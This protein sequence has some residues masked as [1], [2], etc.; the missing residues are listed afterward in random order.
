MPDHGNWRCSAI[1]PTIM[2]RVA[3]L[4]GVVLV[5]AAGCTGNADAPSTSPLST[6]SDAFSSPPAMGRGWLAVDVHYVTPNIFFTEGS[7]S[8]LKVID[9]EGAVAGV[10]RSKNATTFFRQRLVPGTY[11]IR[12]FRRPCDGSC[13]A[14]DPPRDRC[15]FVADVSSGTAHA[16]VLRVRVGDYSSAP[17]C[18]V[19]DKGSAIDI[20]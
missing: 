9:S 6:P 5:L 3:R 2:R 7:I 16:L 15:T 8:F 17:D 19:V 13:R 18:R 1:R 4:G 14:L 20:N 12:T 11:E 10:A